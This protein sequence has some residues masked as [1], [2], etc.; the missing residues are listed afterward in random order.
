MATYRRGTGPPATRRRWWLV[1]LLVPFGWGAWVCFLYAGAM[2]RERRW[3]A[4]AAAYLALAVAAIV[5]VSIGGAQTDDPGHDPLVGIG[6]IGSVLLWIGAGAHALEIRDE[7]DR[8]IDAHRLTVNEALNRE[9]ARDLAVTEPA[10]ARAIG[11]GR[12]DRPAAEHFGLVDVN[13]VPIETLTE[14]PGIDRDTAR[15]IEEL[16]PFGTVE[17]LGAVLELEPAIVENLKDTTIFI[18][19]PG[20]E[21][22][23]T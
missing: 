4:A 2:A 5:I 21:R 9:A 10:M 7:L 6:T 3:L 11:V 13:G 20:R 12:P 22:R 16:R 8:R 17:D 23:W 15:R 18:A 19:R 1:F 14:L